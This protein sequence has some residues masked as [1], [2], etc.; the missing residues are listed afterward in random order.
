[1]GIRH[2]CNGNSATYSGNVQPQSHAG[3]F[4]ARISLALPH[5]GVTLLH[6]VLDWDEALELRAPTVAARLAPAL[7]AHMGGG[8]TT[9][10]D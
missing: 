5:M 1:M 9:L 6:C 2:S 4:A 8:S 3:F 10:G 7:L